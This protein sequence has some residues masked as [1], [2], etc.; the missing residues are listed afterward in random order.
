[1]LVQVRP[2][3]DVV[4]VVHLSGQS[5]VRVVWPDGSVRDE[6]AEPGW[7]ILTLGYSEPRNQPLRSVARQS[8]PR[9]IALGRNSY[10]RLI[11]RE[12]AKQIVRPGTAVLVHYAPVERY[13][14]QVRQAVRFERLS[15]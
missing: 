2:A 12:A 14:R 3:L 5:F 4:A 1:M 11:W 7:P 9:A 8:S 10:D 13:G 6:T 15:T